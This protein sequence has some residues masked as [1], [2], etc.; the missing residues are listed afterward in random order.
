[1]IHHSFYINR[2]G[3]WLR[4][5]RANVYPR[6]LTPTD[7]QILE[8]RFPYYQRLGEK[9]RAEFRTKLSRILSSKEFL[10]RGGIEEVTAEM[11][12]LIGATIV[13]VTF[14]WKR[15]RLP[16]F[17]KILIYPNTYYSTITKSYHHGEVNPKYGL[18]V[19]SWPSFL[20][21]LKNDQDG[22]N[23]GV[24]EIAHA[25]KL[26]NQIYSNGESDFFNPEVWER[27]QAFARQEQEK[28][29]QDQS[30]FR[31]EALLNE[32]EFFAV[33]LENFFERPIEFFSYHPE[34]YGTI[35]QLLRQDP[36][37][38]LK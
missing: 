34:M 5:A 7:I 2:V 31:K 30:L 16:H 28:I 27:F 6:K 13:M 4:E 38:W 10:G 20:E 15:I 26:E 14:G 29:E 19:V 33:A 9:H 3:W 35:V 22:I 25:L 21:G 1:M 18:I 11:E 36:R 8:H 17:R 32:H 23:L 24:H 37:V 12:I